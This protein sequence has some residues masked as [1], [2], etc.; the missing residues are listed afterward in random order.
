MILRRVG[1]LTVLLLLGRAEAARSLEYPCP[2][3]PGFCYFDVAND[4]CFDPGTDAGPIEDALRAGP[5]PDPLPTFGDLPT[6][7]GSIV[8][9]PSVKKLEL[10]RLRATEWRTAPGSDILIYGAKLS[11]RPLPVISGDD[12]R[13]HAGRDL[14]IEKRIASSTRPFRIVAQAERN[15]TWNSGARAVGVIQIDAFGGDVALGPRTSWRGQFFRVLAGGNVTLGDKVRVTTATGAGALTTWIRASGRVDMTRPR[16]KSDQIVVASEGLAI[17][18]GGTLRTTGYPYDVRLEAGTGDVEIDAVSV[19][20]LDFAVSGARIEL[21]QVGA[22]KSKLK[23][24]DLSF[25]SASSIAIANVDLKG[26]GDSSVL[27]TTP[28]APVALTESRVSSKGAG[29][30]TISTGGGSTC[31]LTGTQLSST[32]LSHDCGVVIGP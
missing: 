1:I 24:E 10:S 9:P 4:G 7:P 27:V 29:E 32:T 25:D 8:C 15:V 2:S 6:T 11:N 3:D 16:I 21:G 22:R 31:D 17:H 20:V 28:G 12:L 26:I 23:G 19:S 13:F 14:L 5:F 30:M 18:L